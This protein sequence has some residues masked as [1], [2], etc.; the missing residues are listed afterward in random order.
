MQI[1]PNATALSIFFQT[2][3]HISLFLGNRELTMTQSKINCL[4]QF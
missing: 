3:P 4:L 2:K 1:N